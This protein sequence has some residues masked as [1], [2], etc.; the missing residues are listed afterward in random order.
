[1]SAK[2]TFDGDGGLMAYCRALL[3]LTIAENGEAMNTLAGIFADAAS[4]FDSIAQ[5]C[6]G[7]SAHAL[8]AADRRFIAE[9]CRESARLMSKG[10]VAMQSHDITDQR[11]GHIAELLRALVDGSDIDVSKVLTE[12]EE[13]RLLSLMEQGMD[14]PSALGHLG[15]MAAANKSVELF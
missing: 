5:R 12:G 10:L 9:R 8:E 15:E 11:L 1:L 14:L 6:E 2:Q 7:V 4:S 13:R 3:A